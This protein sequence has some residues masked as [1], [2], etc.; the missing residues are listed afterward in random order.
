[1]LGNTMESKLS[2]MEHIP[3]VGIGLFWSVFDGYVCCRVIAS[4][5]SYLEAYT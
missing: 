1:M 4:M 3:Y 5:H 2:E